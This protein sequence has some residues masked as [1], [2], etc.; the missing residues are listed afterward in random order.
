VPF[1]CGRPSALAILHGPAGIPPSGPRNR[2]R[3]DHERRREGG[4]AERAESSAW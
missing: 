3:H 2:P 1:R 4:R